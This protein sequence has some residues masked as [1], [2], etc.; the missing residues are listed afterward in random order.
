MLNIRLT[1]PDGH[2]LVALVSLDS[3]LH[4]DNFVPQEEFHTQE[5]LHINFRLFDFNWCD[6]FL[7]LIDGLANGVFIYMLVKLTFKVFIHALKSDI[8]LPL[9][10]LAKEYYLRQFILLSHFFDDLLAESLEIFVTDEGL[11]Q[12]GVLLSVEFPD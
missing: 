12:T 4:T 9:F 6:R 8:L 5:V 7:R 3:A 2:M 10:T 11:F 1:V